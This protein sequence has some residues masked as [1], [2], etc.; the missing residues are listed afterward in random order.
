MIKVN[1]FYAKIDLFHFGFRWGTNRVWHTVVLGAHR[2]KCLFGVYAR[3]QFLFVRRKREQ[4]Q[5]KNASEMK[6]KVDAEDVM[7]KIDCGTG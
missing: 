1:K 7:A 4:K 5:K 3:Q 6:T 2:H